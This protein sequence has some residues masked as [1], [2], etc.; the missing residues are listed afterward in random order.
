MT[1]KLS[2]D[3]VTARKSA[4]APDNMAVLDG[5]EM[6]DDVVL[7]VSQIREFGPWALLCF[8]PRGGYAHRDHVDLRAIQRALERL[9]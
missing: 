2:S 3:G 1:D 5:M 7:L 4:A 8:R 9:S 6:P